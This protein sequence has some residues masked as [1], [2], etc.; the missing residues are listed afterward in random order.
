[1]MDPAP[2]GLMR[3]GEK[4]RR[5]PALFLYFTGGVSIRSQAFSA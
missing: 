5:S 3:P 1:M 2:G 4:G